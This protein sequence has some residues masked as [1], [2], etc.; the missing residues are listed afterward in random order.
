[1]SRQG[2]KPPSIPIPAGT[3]AVATKIVD[4]AYKVHVA[5]GPGLLESVY[6]VCL[7]HELT[8]HG[9]DVIRQATVPV[10]YDG[11]KLDTDLRLDLVVNNLVIVE[12][13]AVEVLLPVHYAQVMSYLKL[14]GMR[15]GLLIN[16]N[17]GLIKDGIHR[18][19]Q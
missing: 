11:I 3:D 15:L 16:F 8:K 18:I 17:V 5:L 4:A 7:V 2:I 12:L 10:Y 9:L 19:A 6:E 13:K 1:M 14:A